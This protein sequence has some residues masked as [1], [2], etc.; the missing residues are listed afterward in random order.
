MDVK[1]VSPSKLN[2]HLLCDARALAIEEDEEY[3]DEDKGE[4]ALAGTLAHAACKHW[5]RPNQLW[6]NEINKYPAADRWRAAQGK[7]N[8]EWACNGVVK[9]LVRTPDEAFTL[10]ISEVAQG[11]ELPRSAESVFQAREFFEII[12]NTFDRMK[13]I[14]MFA[15]LIY[16]GVLDNNVPFRMIIDL[17]YDSGNGTLE[18]IDFKTGFIKM[19]ESD[20]W[21]DNQVLMNLMMVNRDKNLAGYPTK[22]FRLFWVRDRDLTDAVILS[23]TQIVDFENWL[24]WEY[25]RLKNLTADNAKETPNRYC[26]GCGRRMKC[27]KFRKLMSEAM[28]SEQPMTEQEMA[29]ITDDQLAVH[30]KHFDLQK[31]VMED[32]KEKISAA[33]NARLQSRQVKEIVTGK[34]KIR[35]RSMAMKSISPSTVISLAQQFN[36]PLSQMVSVKPKVVAAMFGSNVEASKQLALA[37]VTAPGSPWIE[38]LEI[39]EEKKDNSPKGPQ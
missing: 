21:S 22:S 15:E 25:D 12:I 9:H 14:V 17:A 36:L 23:N 6:V 8:G 33:L 18:L 29:A 4:G 38:V 28:G 26:N 24:F 32:R 1:R 39:K 37:T 11:R 19:P 13:L 34:H 31:K 2:R 7:E 10:A 16:E 5:F 35:E 27:I 20:M 3:E 30:K